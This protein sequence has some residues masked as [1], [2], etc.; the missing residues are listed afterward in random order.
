MI[1]NS[2]VATRTSSSVSLKIST[3]LNY[4][5]YGTLT[6]MTIANPH[7][8]TEVNIA[9]IYT[10]SKHRYM[11]RVHEIVRKRLVLAG[12]RST[13]ESFFPPD[14]KQEEEILGI[15]MKLK[16]D[17]PLTGRGHRASDDVVRY[18]RPI[19]ITSLKGTR[20]AGSKYSY[21]GFQQLVH[22]SSGL[23]RYFLEPAAQMF[24]KQL[25]QNNGKPVKHI[26]PA[27][28]NEVI[29]D[30][31]ENLLF[32]EFDK[33]ASEEGRENEY[34]TRVKQ[35]NNLV[36][37]LGGT[38]HQILVSNRSERRV[39]SIALSDDPDQEVRAVLKLG[40]QQGYFHVSSLGNK[41][42]TGRTLLYV[43]T[44][45]L[46]PSFTLDPL[47]FVGYLFVTNHYL[48]EAMANPD[49]V[50]RIK[51]TGVDEYFN[52]GQLEFF[53]PKAV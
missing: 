9:T 35:L 15:A 24:A 19:Y 36:R 38:F 52:S 40:V 3:Q 2:W 37:S 17:W 13:P 27:L 25:S 12:I 1:L 50:K 7:D 5:T 41:E 48:R 23:I 43:L 21:A 46:A 6:G 53:K 11:E 32:D 8:Y 20:K 47:G 29:R 4:K 14:Q 10:S 34:Y 49:V 42:G 22:I 44:R 16:K 18:A 28:Q 45:R 39:I 31:S 33:L 30:E 51:E 26:L